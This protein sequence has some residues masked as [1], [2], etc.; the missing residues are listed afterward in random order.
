MPAPI[1]RPSEP[2]E[3]MLYC[4]VH[5]EAPLPVRSSENFDIRSELPP[6]LR[7]KAESALEAG[8][9]LLAWFEPD[10][11]AAL[12]Y[13]SR[14]LLLTDTRLVSLAAEDQDADSSW[15]LAP[16]VVLQTSE[17]GAAQSLEL[18]NGQ[19]LLAYWRYTPAKNKLAHHFLQ[20][21]QAS[22]QWTAR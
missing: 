7:A 9:H 3:P 19:S 5:L 22:P 4:D 14:L 12:N 16:E 20:R 2:P 13:S 10:L 17:K 18:V 1:A 11:D 21:L 6:R 15:Q 8:E